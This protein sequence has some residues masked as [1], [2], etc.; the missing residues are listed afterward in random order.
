M[1]NNKINRSRTILFIFYAVENTMEMTLIHGKH[2][3]LASI[4]GQP[5]ILSEGRYNLRKLHELPV[6]LMR[7]KRWNELKV[8][9]SITSI[10][11][12]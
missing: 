6:H 5:L 1:R 3:G 2:E 7:S 10:S 8:K 4:S 9:C 11:S 12:A